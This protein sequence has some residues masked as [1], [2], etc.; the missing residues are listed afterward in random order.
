MIRPYLLQ[1][2]F[3]HVINITSYGVDRKFILALCERWRPETHTFHLPT[4]EC[5]IT[6]ED[7]HMLLGLRVDG[8]A[9]VGQTN[10]AYSKAQELL[11]VELTDSDRKGQ[12][13]K[14][15]WL[16]ENYDA[17]ELNQNSSIEDKLRKTRMYILLLFGSLL[18][19]DTNGNT[20]HIQF[21]PLLEN[22]D[23][24]CR[25]SWGAAT[26]AHLYRNLCRCAKKNVNNFAGC[27]VLL[28]AWGWSRMPTLAPINPNPFQFPY[29]TK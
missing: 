7:V 16:K 5:T 18:F 28:Q 12:S 3:G 4:G 17:L 11:G 21:L 25:Y 20:V 24:I 29:G 26:L 15:T 10:V 6:L 8:L 23:K 2:G 1:A 27:G 22:L 14:M 19:A 9:V 13:I